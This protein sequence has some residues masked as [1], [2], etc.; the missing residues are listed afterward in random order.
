MAGEVSKNRKLYFAFINLE[1]AFNNIPR[2]V[3]WWAMRKVCVEERLVRV[4]HLMYKNA[5]S[6]ISVGNSY[7]N[8]FSVKVGVDPGSVLSTA[9]HHCV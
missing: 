5:T 4:L 1:K 3:L 9:I 6:Q 2:D 8:P 7:S